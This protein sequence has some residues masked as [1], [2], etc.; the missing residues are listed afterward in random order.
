MEALGFIKGWIVRGEGKGEVGIPPLSPR[1]VAKVGMV[2]LWIEGTVVVVG[3]R[4]VV[5]GRCLR[6]KGP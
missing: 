3:R 2:V 1:T 4:K 6:R 5:M